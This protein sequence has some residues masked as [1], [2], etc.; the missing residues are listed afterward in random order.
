MLANIALHGLEIEIKSKFPK[1]YKGK[2]VGPHVVRYADDFVVLHH[3]LQVI[4]QCKSIVVDWLK[5]VGLELK[6]SKTRI[7]H[8]AQ[9]PDGEAGFDFLGFHIRQHKVGKTNARRIGRKIQGR[10]PFKTIIKPSKEAIERHY[11]KVSDAVIRHGQQKQA[12]LIKPS[13]PGHY[14]DGATTTRR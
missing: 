9:M 1:W 10:N 3:D 4:E 7:T 14:E 5:S 2:S 6:E 12:C 11:R 8:T 13:Q